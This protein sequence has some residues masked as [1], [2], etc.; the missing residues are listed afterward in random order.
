MYADA[1]KELNVRIDGYACGSLKC[2][3]I[4]KEMDKFH[5]AIYW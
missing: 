1:Y 5:L 4:G 3:F 2:M